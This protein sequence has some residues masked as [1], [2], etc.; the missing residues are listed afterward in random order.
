MKRHSARVVRPETAQDASSAL[1]GESR[2]AGSQ[3]DFVVRARWD[4]AKLAAIKSPEVLAVLDTIEE[5]S[6][7]QLREEAG[8][9][10]VRQ[11]IHERV[12]RVRVDVSKDLSARGAAHFAAIQEGFKAGAVKWLVLSRGSW[13]SRSLPRRFNTKRYSLL[14][15]H[16][17]PGCTWCASGVAGDTPDTPAWRDGHWAAHT[18]SHGDGA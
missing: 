4:Q 16:L 2:G 1:L 17:G 18:R 5:T 7:G 9:V 13:V 8:R 12:A 15:L 14:P 6:C 3:P 10:D 11:S